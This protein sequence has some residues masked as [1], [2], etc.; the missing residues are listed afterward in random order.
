MNSLHSDIRD[1]LRALRLA[2]GAAIAVVGQGLRG[3]R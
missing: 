2:G 3:A 1:C